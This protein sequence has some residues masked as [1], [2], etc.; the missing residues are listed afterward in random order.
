MKATSS[1]TCLNYTDATTAI[2]WLCNAYGFEKHLVVNEDN[3]TVLHS[4]LKLGEV[5]IMVGSS[6][7]GGEYCK[8]IKHPKEVGGMETQSPYIVI[9]NPDALYE[10]AKKQ[11]AKIAIEIKTEDYVGRGFS[12][13]DPEG[14]LWNFGSYNPWKKH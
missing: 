3:G 5:M 12:C 2:E 13:Y 7:N 8:L 1:I 14:H 4:E 6:N 9:D 11:G 10:S